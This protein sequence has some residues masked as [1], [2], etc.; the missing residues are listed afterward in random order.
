MPRGVIKSMLNTPAWHS[1]VLPESAPN[2]ESLYDA[3]KSLQLNEAQHLARLAEFKRL[4]TIDLL[5]DEIEA[6]T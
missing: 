4:S 1:Q 5:V 3:L 2:A 6:L